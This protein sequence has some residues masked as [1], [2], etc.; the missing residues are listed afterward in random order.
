MDGLDHGLGDSQPFE[1][2]NALVEPH[3]GRG[4]APINLA[5]GNSTECIWRTSDGYGNGLGN[6]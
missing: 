5:I 2:L 6:G 1:N 3:A 4:V